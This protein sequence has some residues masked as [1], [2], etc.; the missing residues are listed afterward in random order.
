MN[1]LMWIVIAALCWTAAPAGAEEHQSLKSPS[2][3]QDIGNETQ[4]SRAMFEEI[5]RVLESPRCVNCHPRGDRPL[6]GENGALHQPLVVRGLGGMGAPPMMC[7]NCH[8]DDH[9]RNVPG[10]PEWRLAP[11]SMAWEGQSLAEICKQIKDKK[12]NGGKTLAELHEHMAEDELVAYGW[13][14]PDHL[15][16]VPGTQEQFGE[17]FQA[18]LDAGAHCPKQ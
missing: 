11:A 3:F 6:Q 1:R 18:W 17:L 16:P 12:R 7:N 14:P 13:N 5:G 2:E 4:R 8:L 15:A 9:A 10:N